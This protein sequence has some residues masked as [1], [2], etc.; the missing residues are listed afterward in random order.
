VHL[1]CRTGACLSRRLAAIQAFLPP[2]SARLPRLVA[3][4]CPA[5]VSGRC[6]RQHLCTTDPWPWEGL[7]VTNS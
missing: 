4:G 5:A 1:H 7:G 6:V 3:R 2:A